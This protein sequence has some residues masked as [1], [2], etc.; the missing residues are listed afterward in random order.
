MVTSIFNVYSV[1]EKRR[2]TFRLNT[3]KKLL[4]TIFAKSYILDVWQGS[5]YASAFCSVIFSKSATTMYD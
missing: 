5:E 1:A 2:K 4:S 3:R